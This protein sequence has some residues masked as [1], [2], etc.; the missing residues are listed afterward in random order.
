[1]E[2]GVGLGWAG[3]VFPRQPLV[4]QI[5]NN[6]SIF[7][8]RSLQAIGLSGRASHCLEWCYYVLYEQISCSFFLNGYPVQFI[9]LLYSITFYIPFVR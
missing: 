2:L 7:N 5:T 6:S 4:H 3:L 8:R 9:D 1:M